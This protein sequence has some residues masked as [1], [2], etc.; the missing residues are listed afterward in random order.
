MRASLAYREST[1][2]PTEGLAGW[3]L[4]VTTTEERSGSMT[5]VS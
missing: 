1:R 4:A 3:Y 2:E 5:G